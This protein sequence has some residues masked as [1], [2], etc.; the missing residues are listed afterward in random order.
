MSWAALRTAWRGREPR[1]QRILGIGA[2]VVLILLG[3]ALLWHPL[4]RAQHDLR[5]RL[6]ARQQDMAFMQQA[7]A[8]LQNL[9]QRDQAGGSQRQGKSLLALADASARKAG[10]GPKIKRIEPL[11]DKRIRL[12]YKAADFDVLI[13]WLSDLK[14]HYGISADDVSLDRA[15]GTGQVNARLTLREH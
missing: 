3:W 2:I 14:R 4:S 10:L 15:A 11:D 1:E 13:A 8:Q 5:T 7:K 9:Q 12:E 6:S